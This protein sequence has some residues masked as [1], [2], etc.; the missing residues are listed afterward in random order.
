MY[1]ICILMA[2][3]KIYNSRGSDKIG[4]GENKKNVK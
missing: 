2:V 4:I 1:L 3:S